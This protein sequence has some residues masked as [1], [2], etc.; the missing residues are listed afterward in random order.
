M[1]HLQID[2]RSFTVPADWSEISLSQFLAYLEAETEADIIAAL[3]GLTPAEFR[4]QQA[5]DISLMM[6]QLPYLQA[7]PDFKS[8]P[9]PAQLTIH[10][11]V[12]HQPARLAQK[13]IVG[14]G[15]DISTI[16]RQRKANQQT[17]DPRSMAQ[18]VLCVYL[19]PLVSGKAYTTAE[20][21]F[22]IAPL[23]DALPVTDA[24]PLAYALFEGWQH[25]QPSGRII[26]T[27]IPAANASRRQHRHYRWQC[28]WADV[29]L[30]LKRFF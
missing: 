26:V 10:D 20:E 3:S 23:I 11:Q 9:V 8:W 6:S 2:S 29:R 12:I 7:I 19:Y 24:L 13:A 30:L 4:R 5:V 18:I 1:L 27:P 15:W 16:Y 25:P 14:Q 22:S 28:Q 17:V 21:A